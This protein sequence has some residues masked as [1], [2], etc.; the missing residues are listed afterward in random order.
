MATL[1][2]VLHQKSGKNGK[3]V[4]RLAIRVT[5]N[6]RS[7][8]YYLGHTL[9]K[10]EFD[11][12]S[13][14]VKNNHEKALLLNRLIRKKYTLIEDIVFE[15]HS[16]GQDL[17]ASRIV[18]LAT[19]NRKKLTFFE[20]FELH[21]QELKGQER[22]ARYN[23]EKARGNVLRQFAK[24][25]FTFGQ[26][27]EAF[28]K[29]LRSWLIGY[30]GLTERSVMNYYVVIR[31]QFNRAI[32]NGIIDQKYYPFGKGKIVIKFPQSIKIGLDEEEILKIESLELDEGTTIWHSRNVFLFSF[33]L[34]GIRIGD[35]LNI[36]WSNVKNGRLYYKMSK[37]N[38]V[39]SLRIPD[40]AFEIINFYLDDRRHE[41]DYIFPELKLAKE[42]D[43][44][45]QLIKKRTA[46]KKFNKYLA[47]IAK[48]CE[49]DKKIT[50]HIARHSFGNIAGDKVSPQML[51]KLYR[52]SHITTTMGYQANFIHKDTDEALNNIVGF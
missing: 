6:R 35:V 41:D 47:D 8:Y 24:G 49:I 22:Y 33:Y 19:G 21:L 34:A 14:T 37:N 44:Q 43:A 28:L 36:K 7:S 50:C 25:D 30:R 1:K 9:K 4:Y 38:K 20:Q 51:Q 46:S 10:T 39:D 13:G 17:S 32:R 3:K 15:A 5:A 45:D 11:A 48:M 16:N 27:D 18:E 23:N 52:H 40:K 31:T 29:R 12:N 42:G 26:I 2:T